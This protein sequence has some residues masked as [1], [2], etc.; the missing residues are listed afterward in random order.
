[1]GVGRFIR[2][3]GGQPV[4]LE[5]L[6]TVISAITSRHVIHIVLLPMSCISPPRCRTLHIRIKT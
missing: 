3:E 6:Q 1:V 4:R 5:T 2:A